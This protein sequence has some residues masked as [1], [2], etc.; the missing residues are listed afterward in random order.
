MSRM[1]LYDEDG[2]KRTL[3]NCK[4]QKVASGKYKVY[5]DRFRIGM[6][7]VG[8][9]PSEITCEKTEGTVDAN[10]TI[11]SAGTYNMKD[12]FGKTI[13][14]IKVNTESSKAQIDDQ[15]DAQQDEREDERED[16]QQDDQQGILLKTLM[17]NLSELNTNVESVKASNEDSNE[18]P[19]KTQ[20]ETTDEDKGTQQMNL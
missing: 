9:N 13:C 20:D 2:H 11:D 5:S 6:I 12:S 3:C 1:V 17:T 16:A 8:D 18:T 7:I 10:I 15:R 14:T 19:N 4:Y